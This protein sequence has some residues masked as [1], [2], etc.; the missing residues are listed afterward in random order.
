M[1]VVNRVWGGHGD[2]NTKLVLALVLALNMALVLVLA[3]TLALA[4]APASLQALW[5]W[6]WRQGT[7][8]LALEKKIAMSTSQEKK[9]T[10]FFGFCEWLPAEMFGS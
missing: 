4:A 3:Q 1:E 7:S 5:H 2:Q 9:A 6:Q 10:P 8:L